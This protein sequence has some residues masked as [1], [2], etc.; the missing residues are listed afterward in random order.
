MT[1]SL[2]IWHLYITSTVSSVCSAFQAPA[3]QASVP[4][5]VPKKYLGQAS[6]MNQ[7]S[8]AIARLA[9]P[10]LAGTL[11]ELIQIQGIIAIDLSTFL[12]ALFTLLL[13][14][15]P[16]PPI[17]Q[18]APESQASSLLQQITY[19]WNYVRLRQGLF[20]L[21]IF[22]IFYGFSVELI[23]VLIVPLLLSCTS[24]SIMGVILFCG[25]IGMVIGSLLVTLKGLGTHLIAKIVV[26]RGL[27]GLCIFI[28]GFKCNP[29]LFG[30]LGFLYYLGLP[31]SGGCNQLIWYRKIPNELQGR[32]FALREMISKFVSPVAYLSSGL[33]ADRLFEPLMSKNGLLADSV[34]RIIG[35]GQGRGIALMM[36][37]MGFSTMVVSGIAYAYPRLR[38]IE[39]EIADIDITEGKAQ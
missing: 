9:A 8:L 31:I 6:G 33:L 36:I 17:S 29:W 7:L 38:R 20:A 39:S 18:T 37:L 27:G 35:V 14:K 11:I 13:L 23:T 26:F 1:G 25:G 22:Q 24:P 34:G 16:S 3:Y 10:V 30:T 5:L 15:F 2:Q 12:F 19:A 21:L 4:V 28:A 32:V